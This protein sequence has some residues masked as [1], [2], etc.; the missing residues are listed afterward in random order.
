MAIVNGAAIRIPA[1]SIVVARVISATGPM[2]SA[3]DVVCVD[4]LS[5]LLAA[6]RLVVEA[7]AVTSVIGFQSLQFGLKRH[8][9]KIEVQIRNVIRQ[10]GSNWIS[11]KDCE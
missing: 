1:G 4:L 6:C 2:S 7:F 8:H 11:R 3:I 5:G 9:F 10:C